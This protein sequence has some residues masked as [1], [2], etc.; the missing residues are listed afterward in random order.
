MSDE[1]MHNGSTLGTLTEEERSSLVRM[2]QEAQQ[3][4]TKVGEQEVIK[5]QLLA[6][7]D[8]IE[9]SAESQLKV[10]SA[11]LG[12]EEGQAW[13]AQADGTVRLQNPPVSSSKDAPLPVDT[14][15][16]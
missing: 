3:L 2:R 11:R 7:L 10:I 12:L 8:A 14:P 15:V 9:R 13:Y 1:A 4:L 16:T 6:K 5:A